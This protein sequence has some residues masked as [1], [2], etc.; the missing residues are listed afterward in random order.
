MN[1]ETQIQELKEDIVL[2]RGV[3]IAGTGVSIAAFGDNR[4]SSG[5]IARSVGD[6]ELR[7]IDRAGVQPT[8]GDLAV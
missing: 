7:R 6:A 5:R 1:Q 8:A 2:N 4:T 3:I